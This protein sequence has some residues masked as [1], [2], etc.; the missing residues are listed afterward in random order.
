MMK[1]TNTPSWIFLS[2]VVMLTL[3]KSA[4]VP[5]SR[6][7]AQCQGGITTVEVD[8]RGGGDCSGLG[9]QSLANQTCSDLQVVLLSIAAARKSTAEPS[10]CIEV[11]VHPGTFLIYSTIFI[12]NQSVILR[13]VDSVVVAFDLSSSFDPTQT[14]EPHYVVQLANLEYAEISGIDFSDS[15][16]ILGLENISTVVVSDC[17]FRLVQFAEFHCAPICCNAL[18]AR[19]QMKPHGRDQPARYNAFVVI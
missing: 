12:G 14:F 17:S 10:S 18:Y 4:G 5:V 2:C 1:V 6:P 7:E 8:Q 16:G 9:T 19:R 13:G 11:V 3:A 15:P